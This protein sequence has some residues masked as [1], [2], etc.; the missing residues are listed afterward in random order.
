MDFTKFNIV[1]VLD[2]LSQERDV[3]KKTD[4]VEIQLDIQAGSQSQLEKYTGTLPVIVKIAESQDDLDMTSENALE[5]IETALQIDAVEAVSVDL[6]LVKRGQSLYNLLQESGVDIITSYEN[7]S[8]TPDEKDL[9]KV[10]NEA[11]QYGDVVKLSVRAEN[12]QDSLTLL[13]VIEESTNAGKTISGVSLGEAGQHTRITGSNYGSKLAFAPVEATAE[14][15][16]NGEIPLDD[17]VS[18]IES[19]GPSANPTELHDNITNSMLTDE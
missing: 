19:Q 2:D 6:D 9:L 13:S 17:L 10:V 18:L 14:D 11:S 3:R 8:A 1:A 4:A 16:S 12:V 5:A 7:T 15:L